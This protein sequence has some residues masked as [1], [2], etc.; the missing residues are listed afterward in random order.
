MRVP[1][2]AGN[3]KLN[4]TAAEAAALINEMLPGLEAVTTVENLICP[5]FLAIPAAAELLKDSKVALVEIISYS[6]LFTLV[7]L[8]P[9]ITR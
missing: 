6:G 9:A 5:P 3:W 2:V 1:L 4:K 8:K 7:D